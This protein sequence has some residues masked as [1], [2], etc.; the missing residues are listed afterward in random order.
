MN[1]IKQFVC[2]ITLL[3]VVA[4]TALTVLAVHFNTVLD[5]NG[6]ASQVG[7][8]INFALSTAI[9][10]SWS[11]MVSD[12]EAGYGWSCL[13]FYAALA[14]L[15]A[16]ATWYRRRKDLSNKERRAVVTAFAIPAVT[17]IVLV[18]TKA[19]GD[20]SGWYRDF[21]LYTLLPPFAIAVLGALVWL[22]LKATAPA[23]TTSPDP[24]EGTGET[25]LAG[26]I[27]RKFR[28]AE[29]GGDAEQ[30]TDTPRAMA[31]AG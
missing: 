23:A 12:Y 17:T 24:T 27:L 20:D 22:L 19:A 30:Q 5:I 11:P 26:V 7:Q 1:R 13:Y 18:A 21:Y 29:K 10:E 6:K 28:A 25:T 16:M 3:R 9:Y 4:F 2:Q 14:L 8:A 31:A 15:G